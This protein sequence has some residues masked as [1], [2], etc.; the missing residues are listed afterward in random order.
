MPVSA[1]LGAESDGDAIFSTDPIAGG[2]TLVEEGSRNGLR[3]TGRGG[4]SKGD[5]GWEPFDKAGDAARFLKGLLD[6]RLR[7]RLG[8]EGRESVSQTGSC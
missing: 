6:E 1:G 8:G 5:R 4:G 7:L 2:I 3:E